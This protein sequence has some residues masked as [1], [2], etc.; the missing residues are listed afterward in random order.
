MRKVA[1]VYWSGTGNTQTMAE[2]VAEAASA[3]LYPA[4]DF[5]AEDAAEYEALAFGCPSM[6]AEDLE[7]A[8]FQP[9][10]DEVKGTL[11]SKPVGLFGSWGWGGG[12]WMENWK[13]DCAGL[14]V[15]GTVI[16]QNDPD[17]HALSDCSALGKQLAGE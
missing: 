2:T 15:V 1:V 5:H 12:E 7:E 11:G 14:N 6:G 10:W 17:D 9:M 3:K 13:K 4:V 8:E 16:C